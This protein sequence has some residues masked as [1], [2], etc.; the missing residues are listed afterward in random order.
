MTTTKKI[1][2][3]SIKKGGVSKTAA[4]TN[5]KTIKGDTNMTTNNNYNDIDDFTLTGRLVDKPELKTI[6]DNTKVANISIA[7]NRGSKASFYRIEAWGKTA[8]IISNLEKGKK[9]TLQGHHK[10]NEYTK[11]NV[12]VFGVSL[13]A[14]SVIY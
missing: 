11:D 8:E 10:Q 12:K 3:K 13:V 4:N 14:D 5:R 2:K 9:V 6:N 1:N 7:N